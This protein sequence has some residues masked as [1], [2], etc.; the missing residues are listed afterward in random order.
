[1]NGFGEQLK[2]LRSERGFSQ[3]IFASK[4]GVHVTNLSKYERNIST[5]SL[6]IAQKMAKAFDISLDQLVYGNDKADLLL[7][8]SQL[9]NLFTKTQDLPDNQKSTVKDLLEAFI[10][11]TNLQQQLTK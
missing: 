10:L 7:E 8:D 5:P 4:I 1:M 9:L 6:D 2:R 11:K 3:E